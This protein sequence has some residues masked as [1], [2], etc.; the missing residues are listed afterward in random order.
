MNLIKV[1]LMKIRRSRIFWILLIPVIVLWIP[2]VI[3]AD[4]NFQVQAEGVTPENNFLVQ[5]FMA[6]A[7]IMYPA[8]MVVCTVMMTQLER[9][10]RGILKMLSL[11]VNTA[12]L[13][14]VKFVVLL[15]LAGIQMLLMTAAYFICAAIV[16]QIHDY[17]FMLEPLKVFR[18]IG[19][20][21]VSSIPMAA[22]FWMLAVC[23]QTP[24]F[25]IG[26]GLVSIVPT[27]VITNTKIWFAYPMSYP[28]YFMMNRMNSMGTG[29]E[30]MKMEWFP[31]TAVA[32]AATVI[33]L[34]VSCIAFGRAERK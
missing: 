17:S 2:Q 19:L 32:V 7:W 6:F 18:E 26:A 16:S 30:D 31:L 29:L 12:A 23:I 28:F 24:I 8:S 4:M 1:E 25:S 3:N 13:S 5:S 15:I 14:M 21:Y 22:V 33:C 34:T 9:T 11:P 20:I 10:N 27:V